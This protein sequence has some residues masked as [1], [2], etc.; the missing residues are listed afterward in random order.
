MEEAQAL[1]LDSGG[2][3]DFFGAL[4]RY[5]AGHLGLSAGQYCAVTLLRERRP[6]GPGRNLFPWSPDRKE[7]NR[8]SHP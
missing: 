3:E 2:L 8:L 1:L 7:T 5:A 6:A 4:V